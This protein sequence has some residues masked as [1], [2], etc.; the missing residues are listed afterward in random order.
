MCDGLIFSY[1]IQLSFVIYLKKF[2]VCTIMQLRCSRKLETF[3][4]TRAKLVLK[5]LKFLILFIISR[6]IS[7]SFKTYAASAFLKTVIEQICDWNFK[8]PL[9][10]PKNSG[11]FE[12][13]LIPITTYP[14]LHEFF[15]NTLGNSASF[16]IDPWNLHMFFSLQYPWKFHVLNPLPTVASLD[17]SGIA[18]CSCYVLSSNLELVTTFSFFPHLGQ[19]TDD[20]S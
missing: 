12:K 15:V 13:Y 9:L 2:H 20:K 14:I 6:E 1:S 8:S 11:K 7:Y 18:H 4:V 17:F 10:Y 16:L 5:L 3:Q 19:V